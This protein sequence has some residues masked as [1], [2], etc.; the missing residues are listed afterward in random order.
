MAVIALFKD[1][2]APKRLTVLV[3]GES[4]F[5][6]ATAIVVSS[7][8]IAMLAQQ[9]SLNVAA[10]LLQFL[11]VFLGGVVVGI[12]VARPAVWMMR[13]FR[14]D[15]MIILTLTVT[16]PFIAFVVAEHFLHVSGVMA[17]VTSR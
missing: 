2:N 1:L 9:T 4:L 14:R 12:V 6:D 3:E 10:S 5:N 13:A 7:I 8:F 16:L 17:V 15:T 11:V